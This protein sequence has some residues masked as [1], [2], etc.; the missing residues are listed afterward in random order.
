MPNM[1]K[2]LYTICVLLFVATTVVGQNIIEWSADYRLQVE[3]FEAPAP[4]S[5][6]MQTALGS[7]SVSYEFGGLSLVTTRNLNQ[8]VHCTFQ[9]DASYL[10]KADAATTQRLLAYQ[11]LIFNL[12]E[13]EARELRSKF[14]NERGR[15]LTKGPGDIHREVEAEHSRRLSEV[16]SDTFHGSGTAEI[17]RWNKWTLEEIEKLSDFCIDCKPSKKKQK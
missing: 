16:E 10:D 2:Y 5:G 11:Q 14:F 9:K 6:Q 8:Y 3:D 1:T 12:Y 17:T 4:N 7:F 15:L 13:L